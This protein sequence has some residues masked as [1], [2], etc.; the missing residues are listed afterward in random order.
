MRAFDL[1]TSPPMHSMDAISRLN[2]LLFSPK[3]RHIDVAFSGGLDSRFLCFAALQAGCVVKA[4]HAYGP[5]IPKNE[6]IGAKKFASEL[7]LPLR[8]IFFNP[9]S[10]PEIRHITLQRCYAC[11]RELIRALQTNR[12]RSDDTTVSTA[13]L[14]DGSNFDDLGTYRPGL[15]ALREAGVRSPLAE[16]G[17]TKAQIRNCAIDWHMHL[18]D[19]AARPCLLTRFAYGMSPTPEELHRLSKAEESLGKLQ[20]KDSIPLLEDFRIRLTPEPVLQVLSA[21][22]PV[23]RRLNSIMKQY[24]FFPFTIRQTKKIS[25]FFDSQLTQ[26][27][28]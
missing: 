22:A 23:P 20:S 6:T 27:I 10:L 11:K 24:G 28:G 15:K 19:Q 18:P 3:L 9:L 25:G 14:C 8:L 17:L 21:P 5:H 12:A 2:K 4:F 7:G 1:V 26:R 16:A 13:C